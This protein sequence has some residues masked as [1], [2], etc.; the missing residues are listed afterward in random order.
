MG[1]IGFNITVEFTFINNGQELEMRL[2]NL[3][4]LLTLSPWCGA[5]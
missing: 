1:L 5:A 4:S 3:D 2:I